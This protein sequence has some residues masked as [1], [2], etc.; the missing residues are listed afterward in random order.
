MK[1]SVELKLKENYELNWCLDFGFKLDTEKGNYKLGGII[2]DPK[3]KKISCSGK[4]TSK[5]LATLIT[6]YE[7]SVIE[8]T[9]V[10]DEN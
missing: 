7:Y 8:K 10:S 1:E 6:M 4:T 2:I 9:L 3:T 5:E